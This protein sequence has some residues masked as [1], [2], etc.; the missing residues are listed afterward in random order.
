MASSTYALCH[1]MWL[2]G[3]FLFEI[4]SL[5]LVLEEEV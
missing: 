1:D 3:L 4:Y 5:L 2:L